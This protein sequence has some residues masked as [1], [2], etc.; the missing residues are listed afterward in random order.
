MARIGWGITG[1]GYFLHETFEVMEKLAEKHEISC[2]LSSAAERVIRVYGLSKKLSKICHGGYYREVIS[3]AKE[4][5][6][7][8]LAGR[9]LQKTYDV[10]IV[11]PASANTVAKAALGISDTLVTNAMAQAEKGR[12]PIIIVPTDQSLG[13]T[14]T[15]L[16]YFVDRAICEKCGS[17]R[18]VDLCPAKAIV[19]SDRLPKI[20]LSKCDGCGAC[21]INCPQGA[22]SFGREVTIAAREVDVENVDKLRKRANF[23]VLTKPQEIPNILEKVLSGKLG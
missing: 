12:V 13:E 15:R 14:K 18:V 10:L 3:E 5:P 1:A 11:S 6:A 19:L 4:G 9:F 21:L 17:C 8:P 16:P 7:S 20:D 2:F 23:A 22:I